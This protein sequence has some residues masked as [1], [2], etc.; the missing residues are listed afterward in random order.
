[1]GSNGLTSARH[2]VF[3]NYLA[4]KY[5]E[6]FDALVHRINIF[7]KVKLTDSVA[8]TPLDAGNWCF[9]LHELMRL[10]LKVFYLN[11][12]QKRFTEWCIVVV[13]HKLRFYIL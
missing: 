1:M 7:G 12:H 2:D 3:D 6:S 11:I 13:V 10:S 8:N 9:H 4:Q 5:P